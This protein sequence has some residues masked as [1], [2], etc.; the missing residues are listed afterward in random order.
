MYLR[1][2]SNSIFVFADAEFDPTKP[3][4][5]KMITQANQPTKSVDSSSDDDDF[6]DVS[7]PSNV[8]RHPDSSAVEH[9]TK[10]VNEDEDSS[11]EDDFVDVIDS[12]SAKKS[13]TSE[14]IVDVS[15]DSSSD[16]DFIS[17]NDEKSDGEKSPDDLFGDI[18]KSEENTSKLDDI[19]KSS[20]NASTSKSTETA[21]SN[22]DKTSSNEV[23]S[24]SLADITKGLPNEDDDFFA[25]VFEK[26]R[27]FN[28]TSLDILALV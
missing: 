16:R 27:H 3:G 17:D 26:V 4:S 20:T 13:L 15:D 14:K 5:S 18:F 12:S 9:K 2:F 24:I 8:E 25:D 6:V 7:S 10:N 21:T 23:V 19:L 28:E 22:V 1:S 11:S